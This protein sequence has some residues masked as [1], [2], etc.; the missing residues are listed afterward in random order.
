MITAG[1]QYTEPRSGV[2]STQVLRAA[3][4][5]SGGC[6]NCLIHGVLILLLHGQR[7]QDASHLCGQRKGNVSQKGEYWI[8]NTV[9][10]ISPDAVWCFCFLTAQN[11]YNAVWKWVDC[12]LKPVSQ[13]LSYPEG[14]PRWPLPQPVTLNSLNISGWLKELSTLLYQ[15]G[16]LSCPWCYCKFSHFSLL[17]TFYEIS[18]NVLIFNSKLNCF[19]FKKNLEFLSKLIINY[20]NLYFIFLINIVN[21]KTQIIWVDEYIK[22]YLRYTTVQ[23]VLCWY[24]FIYLFLIISIFSLI[25]LCNKWAAIGALQYTCWLCSFFCWR[26]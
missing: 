13:W 26:L 21:F 15:V 25:F 12:S 16:V 10:L 8:F 5:L 4:G 20:A 6:H 2:R 9:Y 7:T 24:L 18:I 23:L 14:W 11:G 19:N 3:S 17:T 22:E 1:P